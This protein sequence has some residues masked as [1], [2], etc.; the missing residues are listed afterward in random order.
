MKDPKHLLYSIHYRGVNE[1]LRYGPLAS[2]YE[3]LGILIGQLGMLGAAIHQKDIPMVENTSKDMAS[4]LLRL[5]DACHRGGEFAE[6]SK[7]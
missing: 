1:E 3:A 4:T 6:R 7:K 5:A 2:T